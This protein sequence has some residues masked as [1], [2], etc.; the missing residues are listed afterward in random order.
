MFING[1]SIP[2]SFSVFIEVSDI[3]KKSLN[4][5]K[6]IIKIASHK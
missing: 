1:F 2:Y 4:K 6:P 5:Y 3:L